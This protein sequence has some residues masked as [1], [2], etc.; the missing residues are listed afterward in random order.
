M[1]LCGITMYYPYSVKD[2]NYLVMQDKVPEISC[3]DL[4]FS[5]SDFLEVLLCLTS[6]RGLVQFYARPRLQSS[7]LL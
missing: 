1:P 5:P 2:P 7:L 6:M 3:Q 4:G